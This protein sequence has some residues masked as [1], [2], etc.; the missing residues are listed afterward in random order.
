M[1]TVCT[2]IVTAAVFTC[3]AS[4]QETLAWKLK[5][6]EEFQI[7]RK[8]SQKQTV[9]SGG[10]TVKQES[11]GAWLFRFKTERAADDGFELA[12]VLAKASHRTKGGASELESKIADRMQG[13]PFRFRLRPDGKVENLDGYEEFLDRASEKKEDAR[14]VLRVLWPIEA[15]QQAL[16]DMFAFLPSEA[17]K[18][19]HAWKR[20]IV[21]P[22]PPFGFLVTTCA[23]RDEGDQGGL[24]VIAAKLQVAYRPPTKEANLFRV[25]KGDVKAE[26]GVAIWRFD[27]TRGRLVSAEKSIALR[28]EL[29]LD[30]MGMTTRAEFQSVNTSQLRWMVR[31]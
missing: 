31:D 21:D 28:G 9:E 5:V 16:D 4:A 25:I 24:R 20:E 27:S 2:A 8:F 23:C 14:K 30:A 12:A 1:R 15:F 19:G 29:T 6:G 13:T 26:D 10:K 18:A 3:A 7:E 17:T 11:S 22:M